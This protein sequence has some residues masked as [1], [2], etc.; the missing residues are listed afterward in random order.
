MITALYAARAAKKTSKLALCLLALLIFPALS[1]AAFD[2]GLLFD[3]TF[4]VEGVKDETDITWQGSL[5]PWFSTLAGKSGNLY[6][7]ASATPKYENEKWSF[8]PELSRT[9]FD[10]RFSFGTLR[11]GRIN[12]TDPLGFIANGLFDGASFAFNIGNGT[13]NTGLWYS[14]LLFKDT[15]GITMTSADQEIAAKE[16]KF[17]DFADTY[18]ASR[19][20]LAA[21]GYDHP[22][23]AG[24]IRLKTSALVQAD[25][26]D[27]KDRLDSQYIVAKVTAPL[28]N[29][30]VFEGGGALEFMQ[31]RSDDRNGLGFATEVSGA[32]MPPT[33]I[34]DRLSLVWRY[35]SGRAD[36][37]PLSAFNPVTTQKQGS[38]LKAK[39]SGLTMLE[40]EYIARL[41]ETFSLDAAAAYFFRTDKKTWSNGAYSGGSGSFLGGEIFARGIWSPISDLRITLGA[42]V[43]L[44][45]LGNA[46]TTDAAALWRLELGATL[47]LY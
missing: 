21:I 45:Q 10:W 20:F 46:S 44:P 15:A 7:S 33:P 8:V 37:G 2:F 24:F 4:A 19:R 6:V 42:G 16:F 13:V 14:G 35:A 38:V 31:S 25:Y 26:N 43:F 12:H 1:A 18:F 9:E 17:S 40:A 36:T 27:T 32:W 5:I 30:F 29:T 22:A 34:H 39:L 23:I 47:A 3:Q 28:K 41:H 11:A